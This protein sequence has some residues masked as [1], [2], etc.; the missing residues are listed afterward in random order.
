MKTPEEIKSEIET[1]KATLK[2][3]FKIETTDIF[4]FIR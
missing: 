2:K 3:R 1:F 4:G